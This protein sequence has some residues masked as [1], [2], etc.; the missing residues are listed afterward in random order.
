MNMP[1]Y[2][3][4]QWNDRLWLIESDG[5]WGVAQVCCEIA[6][7]SDA[8]SIRHTHNLPLDGCTK[9]SAQ[10]LHR[11]PC[12]REHRRRLIRLC[13]K[14]LDLENNDF[15]HRLWYSLYAV[16]ESL[17]FCSEL[18]NMVRAEYGT[19]KHWFAKKKRNEVR[20]M[21]AALNLVMQRRTDELK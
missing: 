21:N 16:A 1:I 14:D 10:N 5:I 15:T 8:G 4:L 6:G 11:H 9:N 12:W 7:S 13:R 2:R 17:S 20:K 18:M 3:V 19:W